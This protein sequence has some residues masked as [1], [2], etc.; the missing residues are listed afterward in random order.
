MARYGSYVC[1]GPKCTRAEA[2]RDMQYV[3]SQQAQ[4]PSAPVIR[5]SLC[6]EFSSLGREIEVCSLLL[7]GSQ[8]RSE[9]LSSVH[10]MKASMD[11]AKA[12]LTHKAAKLA[13]FISKVETVRGEA[14]TGK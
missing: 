7:N 12:E 8:L 6:C 2:S 9:T 1:A 4:R 3:L 10:A 14:I 5:S 11:A 13:T